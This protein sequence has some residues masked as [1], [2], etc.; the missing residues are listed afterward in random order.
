VSSGAGGTVTTPGIGAFSYCPGVVASL[1]ATPDL[2]YAFGT[3]T[4]G[5]V[6]N[7]TAAS[8]TITMNG[9]YT[10][11]A[12]FNFV[13]THWLVVNT[14]TGGTV[15]QPGVG[16]T[17]QTAGAQVPL[18]AAPDATHCFGSWTGDVGTIVSPTAANTTITMNGDYTITA[19]FVAK[20]TLTISSTSGGTVTTPGVGSFTYCPGIVVS[21]VASPTSGCFVNW[22]GGPVGSAS[23]ASTTITMNGNYTIQANFVAKYTLTVTSGT[24]GTVTTPGLGSFSYCPGIVVSLVAT[25]NSG[26]AFVNWTGNGTAASP[27]AAST[28]ITMNGSYAIQ[29]NFQSTGG[30]GGGGG[31]GGATPTPTPTP[32]GP[33]PTPTPVVTPP[34]IPTPTPINISGNVTGNGTVTQTI[35]YSVLDGQAVLTIGTGTTALTATGGP[36]QSVA[37]VEVCLNIPQPQC[38]V[39]CAYDYT[40]NGATF[41]PAVTLTLKYDPGMV[42][43]GVDASKLAIAYYNTATS[44]WVVVA[45]SVV[46]TVN[47]TV[48]AQVSHFTLFAVYGCAPSATPTPT[49]TVGPTPTPKPTPT[50]TPVVGGKKT[51]IGVIIG[52]IIAVII[53]ALVAYWFWSRRRKPPAPPAAAEGPKKT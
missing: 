12:N 10:I 17:T 26:Y 42:P 21:L 36:L 20:Y 4:G 40:P 22:T 24:G 50:P 5:P 51:N 9:N 31:G 47:H 38:V 32:T 8:T 25:A 30:G 48:T 43:S 19:N 37:V 35:V 49:V 45:G 46:D 3:W 28:T 23:A 1:V 6:G 29:A 34:P 53:I 52:P 14:T 39:G 7:A 44:K 15:T 13:G 27:T 18:V 2:G 16:N 33:T 11:Q 41:S